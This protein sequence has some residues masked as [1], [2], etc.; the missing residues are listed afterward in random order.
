MSDPVFEKMIADALDS[1]PP[2][3]GRQM[4]NVAVTWRH[5]PSNWQRRGDWG[6]LLGLYEGVDLTKRSPLSYSGAPPDRITVF[7]QPHLLLAHDEA[8]LAAMVRKTVLHEVA[9][10]FGISDPR[11]QELG[12]A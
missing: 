4:E 9:H 11:L 3:L 2:A 12:W 1:I 8:E 6:M 10:H 7:K 5:W